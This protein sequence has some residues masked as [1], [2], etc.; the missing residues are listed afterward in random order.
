METIVVPIPGLSLIKTNKNTL[1]NKISLVYQE[2]Q[3]GSVAKSYMRKCFQIHSKS[4]FGAG[5]AI[6]TH[7][8]VC[9][10]N[11]KFSS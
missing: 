10:A 9:M 1:T 2:I 6:E 8:I 4:Q 3:M 5:R 11:R 7:S